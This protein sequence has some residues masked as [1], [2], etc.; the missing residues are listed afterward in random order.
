MFCII[1]KH[2]VELLSGYPGDD[3]SLQSSAEQTPK[4]KCFAYVLFEREVTIL[5]IEYVPMFAQSPAPGFYKNRSHSMTGTSGTSDKWK[6]LQDVTLKLR[7]VNDP[8]LGRF[9]SAITLT[10]VLWLHV[11]FGT[12]K[13]AN[14]LLQK[15][16]PMSTRKLLQKA[17]GEPWK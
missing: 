4:F 2:S 12:T 14:D 10:L 7:L 13:V 3:K 6:R 5:L 9:M 1:S 15:F 8:K 17:M 16:E 11:L